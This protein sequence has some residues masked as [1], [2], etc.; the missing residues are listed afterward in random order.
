M[1]AALVTGGSGGVGRV[2]ARALAARGLAVAI[3]A[4]TAT[5]VERTAEELGLPAAFA[6]DMTEQADVERVVRET[7]E[8]LGAIDVL[9][10][11]AG[12]ARAIGPAWEVEPDE[13]WGDV[14]TTLRSAFLCVQAVVPAMIDRRAGR[15]L[16][17]S[18][19]VAARPTP[20]ISG[21]AAAKAALTSFSDGLAAALLEH[22]V[23][24]FTITPGLFRSALT[25]NLIESDAGRRWLADVGNGR[26]VEPE[27]LERLVDFVASGRADALNG[28]FLHALDDL[29]ELQARADEI[30]AEDLFAV[31]FRR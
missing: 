19:Y 11:N 23:K 25:Q 26:W 14:E 7:T 30:A 3:V 2:I 27:R 29:D 6:G 10:N 12:T 17:V 22:G 4:R 18:S 21:Y 9:V 16:N 13:W 24:V 5:E 1:S 20:Y 15:I 31:R 28:R 8:Q